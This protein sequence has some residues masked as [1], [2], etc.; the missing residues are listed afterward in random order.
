MNT[1]IEQSVSGSPFI[2]QYLAQQKLRYEIVKKSIKK[3]SKT[4]IF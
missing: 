1:F 2:L 3:Y 4:A